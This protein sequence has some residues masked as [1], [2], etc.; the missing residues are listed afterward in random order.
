MR[1]G[2]RRSLQFIAAAGWAFAPYLLFMLLTQGCDDIQRSAPESSVHFVQTYGLTTT[3]VDGEAQVDLDF[4]YAWGLRAQVWANGPDGAS[5]VVQL[6]D[7]G[8]GV[9][10]ISIPVVERS[11]D[12]DACYCGYTGL[13]VHLLTPDGQLVGFDGTSIAYAID[14]VE[15]TGELAVVLPPPGPLGDGV[16]TGAAASE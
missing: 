13:W 16:D 7:L 14:W 12:P 1:D 8:D 10:T 5:V 4:S 6:D 11:P 3:L 2:W 15:L 9:I